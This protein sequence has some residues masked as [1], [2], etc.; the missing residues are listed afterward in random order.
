MAKHDVSPSI[1]EVSRISAGTEV[2]GNLVSKTDIRI[3][4]NFEGDLVTSGKLVIGESAVVRG[5]VI[6]ASADIWGNIEGEFCSRDTLTLKSTANFTGN[7]K[8]NRI[9]I[10]MGAGFCGNCAIISEEE[11]SNISSGYFGE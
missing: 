11:F 5:N 6:C 4:G 10:E 3:D 1:N 7:L 2:K 8:T 9:C